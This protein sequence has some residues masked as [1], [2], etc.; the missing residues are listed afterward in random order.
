M[1]LI[2]DTFLVPTAPILLPIL[3]GCLLILWECFPT[4]NSRTGK[5]IL[6]VLGIVGSIAATLFLWKSGVGTT[7]SVSYFGNIGWLSEFSQSY[8][9]DSTTLALYLGLGV[10]SLFG[11]FYL[12]F[13]L[14]NPTILGEI[15]SLLLFILAGMLTLIS[16][17]NLM[18]TFLALELLSLPT[19]VLVGIHRRDKLSTE[20]SLKYFLFGS[21]ASVL[22]VFGAALLYAQ[23]GSLRIPAIAQM[24]ITSHANSASVD[25]AFTLAGFA[26]LTVATA[27]K[28]G[29]V[30]FH[31]W[32]P[33]V[34]QGAPTPV[35]GFMGSAVKMAAFGLAMRIIWGMFIPIAGQ[36]SEILGWLAIATM[37][38]GNLAA[39]VQDNLKRMFA[40][41]SV[42]HAGYLLLGIASIPHMGPSYAPMIYY[43]VV[44]GLMF[45]GLFGVLAII[46]QATQSTDI[47]D[48]SGLGASHPLLAFCLAV[49]ALSGAG[50]PPT[51]GFLAKYF[52]FLE[53][54]RA[55]HSG[56]VVLAVLSS[57]A[58]AYYYL[59]VVVYLY[60]KETR[61][62]VAFRGTRS[63]AFACVLI[64][65]LSLFL[66]TI[67]PSLL[68]I[69]GALR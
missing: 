54:V 28:M 43:L 21:F 27:F 35:T 48:L 45:L 41:S 44:Y 30:P 47:H 38:V 29:A 36:W 26:L 39:I 53:A 69:G 10:F 19:Y 5:L 31:M 7:T 16:S 56:W 63:I 55:G 2:C 59:R 25:T 40:Y 13:G 23:F 68:G 4:L 22:F 61:E 14:K 37:F 32:V 49:F 3:A 18:I 46:E 66:F 9:V 11:V 34:Y 51:A 20:A 62:K 58:G 15:Y 57:L 8:R 33:D 67:S 12:D 64:S 6:C 1:K 60:M 52:V 17:D 42:A 50:I 65:M 24:I